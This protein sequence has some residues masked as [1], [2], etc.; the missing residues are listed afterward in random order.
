[1][2]KPD[3]LTSRGGF[4][5]FLTF[6]KFARHQRRNA[7]RITSELSQIDA[8]ALCLNGG[9]P[10]WQNVGF[11]AK[12]GENFRVVVSGHL[13]L[14]KPLA[15]GFNADQVIW[16]RIGNTG[17][18]RKVRALDSVFTAWADGPIE[19]MAK[20]LSFWTSQTG[21]YT[22]EKRK[23]SPGKVGVKIYA[24]EDAADKPELPPGWAHHWQIGEGHVFRQAERRET[25]PGNN[26]AIRVETHGDAGILCYDMERDFAPGLT[27][28]WD[29][30]IENLPSSIAE[31]MTF[32]HDY[33][34]IAVEFDNGLD[35]TYMW[36]S[37]LP[38]GFVFQCPLDGWCDV[39]T[40]WVVRSGQAGLGT[41]Q[42]ESRNLWDDY[43]RA[44]S[45][46]L[47]KKAVKVWL[48]ANTIFARN[49]SAADFKNIQMQSQ[50]AEPIQGSSQHLTN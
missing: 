10:D 15:L 48:I 37:E 45:G 50:S 7:A 13:W 39:E 2:S 11:I 32:T 17:L 42:T 41:W 43:P 12:K 27:L 1:M 20:G 8:D 22:P 19:V 29:W 34:S 33:L 18:I 46:E 21:A 31:D 38:E 6:L 9:E 25:D 35:L 49:P 3:A 44:I 36:S 4:S 30:L 16:L 24:T 26:T 5:K 40:H 47:P 23:A 14:A 28:S